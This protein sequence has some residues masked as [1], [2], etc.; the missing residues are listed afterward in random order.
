MTVDKAR[1]KV[2]EGNTREAV[3]QFALLIDTFSGMAKSL[4]R[5]C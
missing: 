3:E 1:I 2:A 4:Y 5:M